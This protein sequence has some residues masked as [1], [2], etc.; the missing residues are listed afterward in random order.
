[1]K[2]STF[3]LS[4]ALVASSINAHASVALNLFGGTLSDSFGNAIGDGG[5]VVLVASTTDSIFSGPAPTS[6]LSSGSFFSGDDMVLATFEI[7]SLTSGLAGGYA[8][9]S[10]LNYSG[11]LGSGDLLQLYWFPTLTLSSTTVGE[12]TNYGAY[13]TDSIVS[14]SNISW[15]LP[16][17]GQ[18][19]ALNF[20]TANVGGSISDSLGQATLTTVPEPATTVALLGGAA[21]VFVMLR[22]RQR[23]SAP[24]QAA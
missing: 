2:K 17:D 22:R 9:S 3:L 23:R 19:V 11:N 6:S 12:G 13:R 21:G 7:S 5:L 24:V 1:M 18:T 16:S 10:V 14:D 15:A 8:F 20:L 4:A